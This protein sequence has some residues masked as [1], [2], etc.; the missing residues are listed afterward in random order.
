MHVIIDTMYQICLFHILDFNLEQ[1]EL[2]SKQVT[3]YNKD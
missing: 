2:W 1:S 3:K